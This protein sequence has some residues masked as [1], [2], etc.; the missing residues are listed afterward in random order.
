MVNAFNLHQIDAC[1]LISKPDFTTSTK[2]AFDASI[3]S[4][5]IFLIFIAENCLKVSFVKYFIF[6]RHLLSC[7]T[8]NERKLCFVTTIEFLGG[9]VETFR[10]YTWL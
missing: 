6:S 8:N 2:V 9:T 5:E 1:H 7:C 3:D 4:E 10:Q